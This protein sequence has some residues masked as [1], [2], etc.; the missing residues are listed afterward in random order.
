MSHKSN[1]VQ[2]VGKPEPEFKFNIGTVVWIIVGFIVSWWN[3]LIIFDYMEIWSY[4]TIIFTTII[5]TIIIALKNRL[6]GYGYLLGF[7]FAG[8]PFLIIVDLFVGGYTF[9][10]AIF[11]FIILWLIFWRAWR[12]LS[13]I[14]QV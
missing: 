9:A 2:T 5:P 12:S 3:M 6:W 14:R 10:T 1:K 8:I 11:I 13:S 4:L 7:S